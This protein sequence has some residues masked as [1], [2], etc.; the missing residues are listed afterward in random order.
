MNLAR[1]RSSRIFASGLCVSVVTGLLA[2]GCGGG[3]AKIGDGGS[4]SAG[5]GGNGGG[6]GG[7]AGGGGNAG[8]GGA[9]GGGGS[10]GSGGSGGGSA[11]GAGSTSGGPQKLKMPGVVVYW[12]QDGYGGANPSDTT[13]YEADLATTCTQNPG[14]G[15]V[16]LAFVTS[17]VNTRNAGGYPEMNFAN[18][19][20]TGWDDQNP[21]LLKC[22]DIAAGIQTCQQQGKIVLLSFGGAS[23]SYSFPSDAAATTFATTAWNL[24]LGGSSSVRPFAPATLD[25]IDLDLEGGASTGYSAFVGAM[26]GLMDAS[27]RHYFIT[28][29]PQCVYPDAYLGPAAGKALGDVPQDF[30]WLNVQFYNNFCSAGSGASFTTAWQQWAAVGP[31][32]M[33]GLPATS[34]AGG[35]YVAPAGL[36]AL[37]GGV[38]SSPA[39]GGAMIWDAG[40]DQNSGTPHYSVDVANAF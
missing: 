31:K 30:D 23:G 13:K 33:V 11:G 9:A 29:A 2:A 16:I 22:P 14:Y 12:G 19:C 4:G 10:A 37:L 27:P 32:V 38:A 20:T 17:F 7:A 6:G 28:A 15:A 18:H 1:L 36:S 26:R 21:F 8:G 35:G 39:F 25:G 3:G 40:F 5:S 24:F 34:Q